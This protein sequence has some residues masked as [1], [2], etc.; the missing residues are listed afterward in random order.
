MLTELFTPCAEGASTSS[1]AASAHNTIA[2]VLRTPSLRE[3]REDRSLRRTPRGCLLEDGPAPRARS[4]HRG[5]G[6]AWPAEAVRERGE[7]QRPHDRPYA[8]RGDEDGRPTHAL[9]EH[10]DGEGRDDGDERGDQQSR[11]TDQADGQPAPGFGDR[12]SE[13]GHD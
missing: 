10:V 11:H 6:H 9:V 12:A 3:G 13:A 5:D 1:A 8:L 4:E 2:S 7:R